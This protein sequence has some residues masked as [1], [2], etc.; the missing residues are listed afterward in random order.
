MVGVFAP[1]RITMPL[2]P[3]MVDSDMNSRAHCSIQFS[4]GA[5][6][7]S[8]K[9][10]TSARVRTRSK[11]R[12][13]CAV[14]PVGPKMYST[15]KSVES[16]ASMSAAAVADTT[17]ME[18]ATDCF[19]NRRINCVA[20]CGLPLVARRTATRMGAA[21]SRPWAP[22]IIRLYDSTNGFLVPQM[23]KLIC[24]NRMTARKVDRNKL[25]FRS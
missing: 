11:A 7:S 10:A 1:S 13:R 8:K 22:G 17:T 9:M 20:A 25:L 2:T 16:C 23:P 24:C 15:F 14:N 18:G 4:A 19:S 3:A 12:L 6:S 21:R 5:K